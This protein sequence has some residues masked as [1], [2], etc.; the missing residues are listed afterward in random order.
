MIRI[1][2]R[3]KIKPSSLRC[4]SVVV[5]FLLFLLF[6]LN[7]HVLSFD[8]PPNR[9]KRGAI[10]PQVVGRCLLADL[11]DK[12]GLT[13]QELADKTGI[14]KQQINRYVLN[15]TIMSYQTARI[16]ASVLKCAMEDLYE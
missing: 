11:L 5:L 16:I 9:K 2:N 10:L 6:L 4:S 13:Q 3:L 1:K 15:K 7:R 12:A 14:P 8:R